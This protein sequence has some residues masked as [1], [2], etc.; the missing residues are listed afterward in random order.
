[1]QRMISALLLLTANLPL[2]AQSAPGQAQ[3]GSKMFGSTMIMML[4]MFVIIYFL[5]IR[6]EQK[7]Q[8]DRQKLIKELKKGDRVL[9][10]SG[11]YGSVGNI[12]DSTVMVKIA[13]NTVIEVA[14][15]AVTTVLNED[16]SEKKTAPVKPEETK[17]GK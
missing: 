12:K 8:K 17:A 7:K 9:L 1:M 10:S 14:K 4:V 2:Y 15:S 13:D 16:G 11:I 3:G 6:P 5:M